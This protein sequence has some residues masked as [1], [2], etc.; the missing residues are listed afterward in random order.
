MSLC[1]ES[2]LDT[3]Q[4]VREGIHAPAAGIT[5][6]RTSGVVRKGAYTRRPVRA[7]AR[8]HRMSIMGAWTGAVEV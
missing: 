7:L 5:N 4:E 2:F 6:Q 3:S 8:E 1:R